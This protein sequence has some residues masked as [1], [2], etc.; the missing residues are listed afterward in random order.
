MYVIGRKIAEI[1]KRYKLTQEAF[2]EKMNLSVKTISRIENG[3]DVISSDMIMQIYEDFG[4]TPN[5]LFGIN[6]D[7]EIKNI[8]LYNVYT[9]Y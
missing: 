2:S 6:S 5:E 9:R 4:L 7:N 3:R 8:D 1:R